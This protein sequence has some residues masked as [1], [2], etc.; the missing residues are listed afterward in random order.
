MAGA[1]YQNITVSR[2]VPHERALARTR[3]RRQRFRRL[4]Y[5]R[6]IWY[7]TSS[8]EE[9]KMRLLF[10]PLILSALPAAAA[11]QETADAPRAEPAAPAALPL[12]DTCKRADYHHADTPRRAESRKL[13]EL[14]PGDVI[15]SVYNQV[16][17]CMEPVIVRYGDGRA[18]AP[19]APAEPV[20]PEARIWR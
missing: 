10:L 2:G 15:L 20:R 17:G 5:R 6:D 19:A 12:S 13:G 11:P 3:G 1:D 14:P 4:H 16:E 7:K 8:S 9:L 18:P